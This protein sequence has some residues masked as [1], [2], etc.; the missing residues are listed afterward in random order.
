[1]L[2]PSISSDLRRIVTD[3]M[4]KMTSMLKDLLKTLEGDWFKG[5]LTRH[6]HFEAITCIDD[7][8]N[9][10][11][12]DFVV[13]DRRL[14]M[15]SCFGHFMLMHRELK[16]SGGII[17]QLLLRELDHY[18]PT[19]EMRFLLGN[20]VV[21]FSKVEFSLITG[22]RFGVV[23]DTS[24]YVAVENDIHQR[25]FPGHDEVSLDDLRVVLTPEEFQQ[26]YDAVKLYL[27]YMLNWILLGVDKRLK[28]PVWQFW[29]VEDLNAFDAFPWDAHVYRHSIFPF[30]H[31]LPRRREERCQ[32]SQSDVV[33]SVEGYNIYGQSHAVLIFAFED[34]RVHLSTVPDP[35]SSADHPDEE[36]EGGRCS[37]TE[38]S[39]PMGV[40]F[41]GMDTGRSESS[42]RRVRLIRVRFT[43]P[44]PGAATGD[45]LCR[46]WT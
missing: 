31:A 6:D 23:P 11:P 14:F 4:M 26:A 46:R 22:L 16:F 12:E 15:A 39:D 25:Y 42:S 38:A 29:L 30:K 36:G 1:M 10:V 45:S 41:S 3:L 18:G 9:R 13:E 20:H 7:A 28:I 32:Q 21:R 43:T 17:H 27:I 2:A 35:T 37:E 24:M 8:L 44:E 34:D 5:K 40:D 19:D 33:H